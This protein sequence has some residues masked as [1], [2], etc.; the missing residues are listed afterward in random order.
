[1][2]GGTAGSRARRG[3]REGPGWIRIGADIPLPEPWTH[4]AW[5]VVAMRQAATEEASC[6][7]RHGGSPRAL[8]EARQ[9]APV[10]TAGR[11]AGIR[12][13][14]PR[15][16]IGRHQTSPTHYLAKALVE[17]HVANSSACCIL[18]SAGTL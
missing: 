18:S 9:A 11:W 4:E 14:R 7:V 6:G 3:Y 10:S 5:L 13:T 17:F 1:V 16:A 12:T 2:S 15:R 8:T